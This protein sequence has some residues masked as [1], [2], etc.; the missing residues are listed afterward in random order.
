MRLLGGR[1]W[2]YRQ[3]STSHRKPDLVLL[4]IIMP[5]K[6]GLAAAEQFKKD[7]DL[8]SIPVLMLTS[9]SSR[10]AG[11]SIARGRGLQLEADDY[12]EKPAAPEELLA[13]V[14]SYLKR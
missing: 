8:K 7:L 12:I 11:S 9:F 10:S 14:E 5:V 1:A 2:S 4:D 6:D 13:K 3:Q